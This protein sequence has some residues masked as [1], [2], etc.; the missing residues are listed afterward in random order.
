MHLAL[1]ALKVLYKVW[2]THLTCKKYRGF[3]LA[4]QA[5]LAKIEDYYDWT[6][7]SDAYTF[8]MCCVLLFTVPYPSSQIHHIAVLDLSQKTEHIWKY[9]GADE[10]DGILEHTEKKVSFLYYLMYQSH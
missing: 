5:G 8:A 9:W 10:L 6:A 7:Q 4:L 3:S 1:P 2:T